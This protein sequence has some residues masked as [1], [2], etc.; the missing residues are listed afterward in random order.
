MY[1]V[2]IN[3]IREIRCRLLLMLCRRDITGVVG[4]CLE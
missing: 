2:N 3:L 4:G 1:M